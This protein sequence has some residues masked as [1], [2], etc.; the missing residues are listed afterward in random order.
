MAALWAFLSSCATSA[1]PA[2]SPPAPLRRSKASKFNSISAAR[3]CVE[4]KGQKRRNQRSKVNQRRQQ[5]HLSIS[6]HS[7]GLNKRGR[8]TSEEGTKIA[9]HLRGQA[10]KI[11][12]L[13][14]KRIPV[15]IQQM[16]GFCIAASISIKC[17]DIHRYSILCQ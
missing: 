14:L 11:S 5:Q 2:P 10:W 7:A 15:D 12:Q 16:L 9:R 3:V 8:M 13:C 1:R 17:S 4:R 6:P